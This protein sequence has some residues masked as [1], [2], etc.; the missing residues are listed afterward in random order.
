MSGHSKWHKIKHKKA[1]TD[2]QKSKMFA[3]ISRDITTQVRLGGND[4]AMNAGL[5]EAIDRAKKANVPADNIERLLAKDT[6]RATAIT[7]EGFG[8]GG[9]AIMVSVVTDNSNRTVADMR[10]IL[11]KHGGSLGAPGSVRWKFSPCATVEALLP[12]P[13]PDLE[14]LELSLIDAG[15]ND[16]SVEEDTILVTAPPD[17]RADMEKVLQAA[18]LTV[19]EAT[20]AFCVSPNQQQKVAGE[21]Q[22]QFEQ[23]LAELSEHPEVLN[24]FTDAAD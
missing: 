20:T 7:Y 24:V 19:T 21:A 6:S 3:R 15:A 14:V 9:V 11:K 17:K 10:S 13:K 18:G 5:R 2:S 8:P 4:P 1:A 23:L 16:F 12:E 22:A